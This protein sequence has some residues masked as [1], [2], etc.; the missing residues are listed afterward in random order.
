[1]RELGQICSDVF[2]LTQVLTDEYLVS[3]GP[4]SHVMCVNPLTGELIWT[5]DMEKEFGIPGTIKGKIT[6]DWYTGQCPLIDDGVAVL[7]P[8]GKA[9]M[10]GIDCATG[11]EL[12]RTPNPDTLRMSHGSIM[13]M[14]IHGKKMY[15]YNA[16]GGVCGISAKDNDRGRL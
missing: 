14:K 12:W 2:L 15:V 16:V 10:I 7:A 11:K 9:L 3:I 4:R 13:P 8:G 5:L 1:M 6:P